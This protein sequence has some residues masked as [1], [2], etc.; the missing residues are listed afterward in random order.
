MISPETRKDMRTPFRMKSVGI[1]SL[2][3]IFVAILLPAYWLAFRAPAV[4]IFHDDGIYL[5][6]AKALAEGKGYRIISLPAELPQT[7]YPILFPRDLLP[8][9]LDIPLCLTGVSR[10]SWKRCYWRRFISLLCAD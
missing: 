3:L 10:G 2:F 1:K 5:V 6:T 4:G 8:N 9:S 7:K